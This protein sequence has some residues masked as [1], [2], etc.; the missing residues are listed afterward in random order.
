MTIRYYT[1]ETLL[2][3]IERP[4]REACLRLLEDNRELF[5]NAPGASK[6]HHNWVGGYWDHITEVMNL[7]VVNFHTLDARR[8]MPF[9]ESDALLVLYLHDLEKPWRYI[10]DGDGWR[11]NPELETKDQRKAFRERKLAEYGLVLTEAQDN[12]MRYV[13]G[14]GK[15]YSGSGRVMNE[16]AGLCHACDVISARVMPTYPAP[17]GDPRR[18]R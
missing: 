1:L 6:N 7:G 12:A 17:W 11:V 2:T 18:P 15:D 9:S 14:E 10:P 16:L 8:A 3:R 13:E 5:L 4:A